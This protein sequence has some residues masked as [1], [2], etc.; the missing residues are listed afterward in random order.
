MEEII[1]FCGITCTEC[2]G[3]IATKNDDNNLRKEIAEEWSKQFGSDIKPEDINCDGCMSVDGRHI[4][5]CH[6]CEIRKCG[7]EKKVTNCAYC[8]EY[9]CE[10]LDNFHKMATDAK[11]TL[12]HI[13]NN[14]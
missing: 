8:D 3:Y 9:S 1:G 12:E 5:Y 11:I 14:L 7:Q 2:K 10:K 4:G 6:I 13:K